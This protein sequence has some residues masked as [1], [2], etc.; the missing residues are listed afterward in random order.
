MHGE[1]RFFFRRTTNFRVTRTLEFMMMEGPVNL[2][3]ARS[4]FTPSENLT[5]TDSEVSSNLIIIFSLTFVKNV[6][7]S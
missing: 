4:K 6:D 7:T 5:L 1:T 2:A 3:T